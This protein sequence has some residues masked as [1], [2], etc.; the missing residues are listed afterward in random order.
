M[1][2]A[3]EKIWISGSSGRL[4][5]SMLRL[6]D[7]LD[8]EIIATDKNE[9]DITNLD[10]VTQ[11]VGRIR[12]HTIINCSGLS[13]RDKCEENP[14]AAFLLNAI[15]ARNIAIAS[16]KYM[17]KLVQLSTADVFDGKSFKTYT[18]YDKANPLSVYGKS[19]YEGENYVREFSNH[20]FIV[21]VS[22]LYSRENQFVENILKEAESG[23]VR[24]S[25][26]LFISPT[27]AHEL[28]DFL[29]KLI[30]TN[31]YGTYHASAD[32]Y[33]SMKDFASEILSYTGKD[34]TI[35]ESSDEESLSTKPGCFALE[36]YILKIT[37][38][39]K[40]PNWKDCLH[41]Y[42]DREGLNGK[43]K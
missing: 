31:Y 33:T 6:L 13:N 12:P 3:R 10:E 28:A 30:A 29:I 17:A 16:N 21:R 9:V 4:G 2:V 14:D 26:D 25:K 15:G 5:T 27:S 34:A 18:E 39:D 1:R 19:K 7:P 41:Q 40:M 36:D 23:E 38:G 24:V 35:I 42:I 43:T 22:R 20:H 37:G 11:F 32:G 8:A